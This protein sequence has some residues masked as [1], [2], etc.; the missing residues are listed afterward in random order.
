MLRMRHSSLDSVMC[1]K[2]GL[3]Q[4]PLRG[5]EHRD[6]LVDH[7]GAAHVGGHRHVDG[8]GARR[9]GGGRPVERV[10]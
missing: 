2:P 4:A 7:A 3:V 8:P 10:A 9:V 6:V 5:L 1:V